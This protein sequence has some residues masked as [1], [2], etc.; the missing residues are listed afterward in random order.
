MT[1]R[2]KIASERQ[3]GFTLTEVLV[4]SAIFTIIMIGALL[5]YDRSNKVFKSG[6]ENADLQQNT[7]VAYDKLVADV[8]MTGFDYKRAGKVSSFGPPPWVASTNYSFGMLVRPITSN[9]FFYRC[10][11]GGQS[12]P[13][14]PAWDPAPGA[15]VVEGGASTVQ[16]VQAGGIEYEQPDE[17]VEYAGATAI[18]V[19]GNYDYETDPARENGREYIAAKGSS[20]LERPQFPVVT[21][22]N[23][24]IVGYALRSTVAA[25]NVDSITFFA[26]INDGGA[27]RRVSFPGGSS[28]RLVT[29]PNVDLS[30]ANPPYNLVRFS[31][32]ADG[33]VVATPIAENIRSLEFTYFED[34]AGLQALR[35]NQVPPALAPNIG[36][37]GQYNPAA[38]TAQIDGRLI[39]GKI[40]SI[41]LGLVGMNSTPDPNFTDVADAVAPNFRKYELSSVVVPRNM[42]MFGVRET[43]ARPPDPPI[44]DSVCYGYCGIAVVS[45]SPAP[46]S[47]T[48]TYT[49]EYESDPAGSK[50]TFTA[51]VLTQYSADLTQEPKDR[52]YIFRVYA[53]NGAGAS[54]PSNEVRA[55]VRNTTTPNA[56]SVLVAS[57]GPLPAP[58]AVSGAIDLTW[59]GPT[60]NGA[61]SPACTAGSPVFTYFPRE[62]GG[63]RI[64]RDIDPNFTPDGTNMVFDETSGTAPLPDGIGGWSFSDT[65]GGTCV[66][67]YYR[68][69]AVEYCAANADFNDPADI[70]LSLSPIFPPNGTAAIQGQASAGPKPSPPTGLV[71]DIEAIVDPEITTCTNTPAALGDSCD[72]VLDWNTVN[73]DINGDPKVITTYKIVRQ[74]RQFGLAIGAP[75]V[76]TASG[77]TGAGATET[78]T[79]VGMPWGDALGPYSFD[80]YVMAYDCQNSDPSNQ[81]TYPIPCLNGTEVVATASSGDGL[82]FASAWIVTDADTFTLS[83]PTVTLTSASIDIYDSGNNL[84]GTLGP[85]TGPFDLAWPSGMTEGETYRLLI[86]A[87]D[88]SVPTPC[89]ETFT[90]Y[91]QEETPIPT[92]TLQT[93]D[94]NGTILTFVDSLNLRLQLQNTDTENLNLESIELSYT[95][96]GRARMDGLTFPSGGKVGVT[97]AV[98]TSG[99]AIIDMNPLPGTL[100]A[101]DAI[102]PPLSTITTTVNW[103]K[104]ANGSG[105]SITLSNLT[106]VCVKYTRSSTGAL[107]FACRVHNS[108]GI[109][110]GAGNPTTCD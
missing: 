72:V 60:G 69:Q 85:V 105:S 31:F 59:Q 27:A 21:T 78:Y 52:E 18:V 50:G 36:G 1:N 8:R 84:V 93:D 3:R 34:T 75:V 47:S 94:P 96:P 102:V 67:Y 4:A 80:Y 41:G 28:E 109:D 22:G 71:I 103:F 65:T 12:R 57:G 66:D 107:V 86:T 62:I 13:S 110:A 92:C 2:T 37:V 35:D 44:I 48:E 51:G 25:D 39:R 5:M 98:S 70:N 11:S 108:I 61:G 87:I 23:D 97:T 88:N 79:D 17:Q 56:P 68:V 42:G 76:I 63:W 38:P 32:A 58:P 14:E 95:N 77:Y 46:T 82:T 53:H 74:Q 40:R 106:K 100:I 91:A 20:G 24:E 9:G 30:N 99:I 29:I 33:S 49:V 45:W 6:T 104:T 55:Y 54:T 101:A 15:T 7:R 10:I 90:R 83:H 19:R 81:V 89:T 26:D 43:D 64:Y 16:W 73:T